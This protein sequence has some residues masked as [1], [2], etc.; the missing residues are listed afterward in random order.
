MLLAIGLTAAGCGGGGGGGGGGN[1]QADYSAALKDTN[2]ESSASALVRV[3]KAFKGAGDSAGAERAANDAFQKAADIKDAGAQAIAFRDVASQMGQLGMRNETRAALKK[4]EETGKALTDA[5]R[6]A[7]VL[8]QVGV[9]YGR[10]LK[11]ADQAKYW[12]GEAEKAV[13]AAADPQEKA[14]GMMSV[15]YYYNKWDSPDSKAAAERLAASARE[16]AMKIEKSRDKIDTLSDIGQRLDQMKKSDEAK[17]IFDESLKLARETAD[18]VQKAHALCAVSKGMAWGRK[19]EARALLDEAYGVADKAQD[20]SLK[21]EVL[22]TI[23]QQK[24]ELGG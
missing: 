18:P 20:S 13:T 7:E 11:D 23:N 12:L 21:T 4:A 3:S 6:K 1:I 19:T 5:P 24:N 10:D 15:A 2:P 17:A 14:R 9:V 8:G 22:S 16:E